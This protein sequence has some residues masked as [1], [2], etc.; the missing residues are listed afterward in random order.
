MPVASAPSVGVDFRHPRYDIQT[1]FHLSAFN[2]PYSIL[3]PLAQV[4]RALE[5]VATVPRS[6]DTALVCPGHG[7]RDTLSYCDHLLIQAVSHDLVHRAPAPLSRRLLLDHPNGSKLSLI[8]PSFDRYHAIDPST[9][10]FQPGWYNTRLLVVTC[11]AGPLDIFLS[12]GSPDFSYVA[13][14]GCSL[15][16][17]YPA[18][19]NSRID[20]TFTVTQRLFLGSPRGCFACN[21]HFALSQGMFSSI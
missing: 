13:Q 19:A 9:R 10:T 2:L 11:N 20:L 18:R 8:S 17:L 5:R 14:Y 7:Y 15:D 4:R 12:H 16:V 6:R 21:R 3:T 1:V